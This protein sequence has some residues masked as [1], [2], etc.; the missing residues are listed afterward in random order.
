MGEFGHTPESSRLDF[1]LLFGKIL[2]PV[3]PIPL[4]YIWSIKNRRDTLT[5][6]Q[7]NANAYSLPGP[8]KEAVSVFQDPRSDE[9]CGFLNM[10]GSPTPRG[11]DI[12]IASGG[13]CSKLWTGNQNSRKGS[14]YQ[15]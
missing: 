14:G 7:C 3:N 2:D 4:C 8:H 6:V 9:A 15:R 11:S 5:G 1:G 10:A 12:F 13:T